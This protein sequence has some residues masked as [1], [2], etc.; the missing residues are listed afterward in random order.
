MPANVIGQMVTHDTN[1]E[2]PL[3]LVTS[4]GLAERYLGGDTLLV[5]RELPFNV[6]IADKESS[7]SDHLDPVFTAWRGIIALRFHQHRLPVDS[8]SFPCRVE[9]GI[10]YNR[11]MPSYQYV[12]TGITVWIETWEPHVRPKD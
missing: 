8:Q 2:Y 4:E 6:F 11:D 5:Q 1:V 10:I 7:Q 9:L 3:V 12:V